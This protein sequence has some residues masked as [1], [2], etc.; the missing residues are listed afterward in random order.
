MDQN[1]VQ[2][3]LRIFKVEVLKVV[4]SKEWV[5]D[6]AKD[7]EGVLDSIFIFALIWGLGGTV[8]NAGRQYVTE[9]FRNCLGGKLDFEPKR[10]IGVKFPEKGLMHD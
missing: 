3:F 10:K 1:L 6:H 5:E 8:D 9:Y 7:I 2:T 4:E